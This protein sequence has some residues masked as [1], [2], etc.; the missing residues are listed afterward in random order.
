[1]SFIQGKTVLV[2]GECRASQAGEPLPK[3]FWASA[4]FTEPWKRQHGNRARLARR[5]GIAYEVSRSYFVGSGKLEDCDSL[6][7]RCVSCKCGLI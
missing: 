5:V 3:G 4:S 7:V 1:M 2:L 6:A